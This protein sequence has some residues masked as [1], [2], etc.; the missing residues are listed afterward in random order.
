MKSLIESVRRLTY[1]YRKISKKAKT[2]TRNQSRTQ[3]SI[4][5]VPVATHIRGVVCLKTR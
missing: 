1:G 5:V 2:S 3:L 4:S